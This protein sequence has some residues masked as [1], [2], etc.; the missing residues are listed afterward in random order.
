MNNAF[1][2]I[3]QG[4][5][6]SR[7]LMSIAGADVH[8]SGD[9]RR[10]PPEPSELNSTPSSG[11]A[12]LSPINASSPNRGL[13]EETFAQSFI[14][15][16]VLPRRHLTARARS[17][18]AGLGHTWRS[19][20]FLS[21]I[22]GSII[23]LSVIAGGS[24]TAQTSPPP[25]VV[26][27]SIAV[28]DVTDRVNFV[29]NVEAIQ[30][31]EVRSRVEGFL[32]KVAFAEGGFVQENALLYQ[33]EQAPYGDALAQAEATLAAAQAQLASANAGLIEKNLALRR[34]S[35]LAKQSFVS[36]AVLDAA[37]A[38]RDEAAAAVQQANAQ[39]GSA[40]AQIS[41][42]ALNLS[43]TTIRS[44]IAGR[45]GKTALTVGNL[46]TPNSGVLAT[47]VQI[48]PIRVAFAIPE[49][50]YVSIMRFLASPQA[51]SAPGKDDLFKPEL[52]LPDGSLYPRVG[53]IEFLNNKI[54][55]STGTITVR[56]VFDNPDGL[57]LD[58]EYVSVSVQTGQSKSSTVVPLAAVMRD[59]EGAYVFVVGLD[60]RV[61]RRPVVLGIATDS[62]DV[63]TSGL[64]E[65]ETVIVDGVQKVRPGIRVRPVTLPAS[66]SEGTKP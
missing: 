54:D 16:H 51:P 7:C 42:A 26:V 21:G 65:G 39:I 62:G 10:R 45:I 40:N 36:Q 56:A 60:D 17:V 66:G 55:R 28:Q 23:A 13:T 2:L 41:T 63:V 5:T 59:A 52:R 44:P 64:T 47:V 33:I 15:G 27:A 25:S 58:G 48:S 29:G 57:L 12:S 46:V 50:D 20:T 1:W 18:D 43:Y 14:Y 37:T 38:A 9:L 61:E 24:A 34:Q 19:C 53:K 22:V 30:Q 49:R 32:E 4:H 6:L 35:E 3:T 31:V 11:M 8:K